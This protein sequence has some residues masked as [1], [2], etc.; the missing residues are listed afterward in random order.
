MRR[1]LLIANPAASGFTGALHREVT[2]SVS[3][4]Y[5]VVPVW[6][7]SAAET[8]NV[9]ATAADDGFEAVAAMGGDGV[10]HHV[11]QGLI[12][13]PT[14]LGIIPVGTTNVLA[15]IIGVPAKPLKAAEAL[16]TSEPFPYRLAHLGTESSVGARSAYATF[17]AGIGFDA[18]VVAHAEQRP[19]AKLY[20]GGLHY[21]KSA[22]WT[23]WTRYRAL[24]ANLT[25]ESEYGR[26]H[27]STVFI[28]VHWPYTYFG[29]IPIR[30]T[31]EPVN[32]IS[33]V[34]LEEVSLKTSRQIVTHLA[35]GRPLDRIRGVHVWPEFNKLT[36]DADPA[37]EFQADGELL[38]ATRTLDVSEAPD[39]LQI[40]TPT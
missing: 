30:L 5:D 12:G 16:A 6:P 14:A 1:L 11:A 18:D 38:G 35:T 15:R 19:H 40:L 17:S 22:L 21:A 32:G 31:P 25:V 27:A 7:T 2:E 4:A 26:V 24:P 39:P 33:A 10:V 29:S 8:R 34:V 9:A 37:A 13:T 28:Q 3:A 20:F 36:I 23:L